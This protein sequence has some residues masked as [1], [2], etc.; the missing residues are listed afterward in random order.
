MRFRPGLAI[1]LPLA[2]LSACTAPPVAEQGADPATVTCSTR[3]KD[4]AP[5]KDAIKGPRAS[6]QRSDGTQSDCPTCPPP[7]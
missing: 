3:E 1:L 7:C 2:A 6:T 4:D 5:T